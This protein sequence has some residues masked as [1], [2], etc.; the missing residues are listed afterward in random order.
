MT[1]GNIPISAKLF[2]GLGVVSS[3]AAFFFVNR[4]NLEM[5][6]GFALFGIVFTVLWTDLHWFGYFA[7]SVFRPRPVAALIFGLISLLVDLY[8]RIGASFFPGNSTSSVAVVFIPFVIGFFIL[9]VYLAVV[10]EFYT[11]GPLSVQKKFSYQILGNADTCRTEAKISFGNDLCALL[12]DTTDGWKTEY[13]S[14]AS[15]DTLGLSAAVAS[16]KAELQNYVN[17]RGENPPPELTVAGMSLW[18]MEKADGTA[19]GVKI[20]NDAT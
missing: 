20:R 9:P 3:V 14:S 6:I 16:A 19:M 11:L 10:G 2:F 18:L 7:I 15:K 13:F 1:R 17:R 12:Y 4:G 5:S 8:I